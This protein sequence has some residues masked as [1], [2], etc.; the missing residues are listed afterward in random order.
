MST[1]THI[2]GCIRFDGVVALG[3]PAPNLGRTCSFDDDSDTWDNCDV[4]CGSEGSIE[5][6][7]RTC[8][9]DSK[10]ARWSAMFYGDLRDYDDH[11]EILEYFKRI[12]EGRMIRQGVFTIDTSGMEPRTYEYD[13]AEN[14]QWSLCSLQYK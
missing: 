13:S 4:P 6:H 8:T 1:W 3:T 14:N 10:M 7:L 11:D 12:T 2:C 9:E 5:H